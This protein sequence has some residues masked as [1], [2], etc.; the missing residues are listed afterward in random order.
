MGKLIVLPLT[1]TDQYAEAAAH[2]EHRERDKESDLG[3]TSRHEQKLS[4]IFL[5]VLSEK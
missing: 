3:L 1:W 5:K 4:D 2:K